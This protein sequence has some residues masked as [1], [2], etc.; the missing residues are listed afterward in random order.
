MVVDDQRTA[1]P[2][3]DVGQALR[4][5]AASLGARAL[6]AV[7]HRDR[8]AA[9]RRLDHRDERRVVVDVGRDG[10]QPAQDEAASQ[11][12]GDGV[13]RRPACGGASRRARPRD[14]KKRSGRNWPM[15]GRKPAS[16][17]CHVKSCASTNRVVELDA[18]R[19]QR[20]D[21]RR[22]RAAGAVIRAGQSLP[23]VAADRHD[24][25]VD[26]AVQL[27]D[28]LGRVLVRAGDEHEFGA[29]A[30]QPRGR[31]AQGHRL[32]VVVFAG[33]VER[34]QPP[35]LVAVRRHHR[36]LRDQQLAHRRQRLVVGED[37][38]ASAREDRVEHDRQVGI[39]GHDLGDGRDGLDVA[40][41]AELECGD[42]HVLE[43]RARL[44]VDV[45]GVDRDEFLDA[46]RVLDREAGRDAGRM[47]AHRGDRHHVGLQPRA[48][49]RIAGGERH[50]HGKHG[51]H[52]DDRW[53]RD[54]AGRSD[55]VTY[56]AARGALPIP[57]PRI[58]AAK[59]ETARDDESRRRPAP[60][61]ARRPVST[62]R[63]FYAAPRSSLGRPFPR[64]NLDSTP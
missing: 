38:A 15:P 42:R 31:V 10:V 27:V 47:A 1:V 26:F 49:G 30:D 7:L 55:R 44:V 58:R 9:Q 8:A 64:F 45:V 40:E 60:R 51:R 23:R 34:R 14:A 18:G 6:V 20:G 36:D 24:H 54:A 12:I 32:R 37:V 4:L 43:D 35:R 3:A 56:T 29:P 33:V 39:V 13:H 19:E 52:A 57:V 22:Q 41:H 16:S 61:R 46:R 53:M 11:A 63:A 5:R 50:H 2:T 25:V 17:A 21:R 62:E 59:P 28:D 48:A